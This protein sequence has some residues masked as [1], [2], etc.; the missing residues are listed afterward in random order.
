MSV[1]KLYHTKPTVT[2]AGETTA[3]GS[4]NQMHI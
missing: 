4:Q 1:L 2:A 3:D